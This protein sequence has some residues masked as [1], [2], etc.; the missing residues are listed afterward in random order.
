MF[1]G[2]YELFVAAS[3][4]DRLPSACAGCTESEKNRPCSRRF[5]ALAW[6]CGDR[7]R[8][9]RDLYPL[10]PIF[11][12]RRRRDLGQELNAKNAR[13]S[14]SQRIRRS[15][16][17]GEPHVLLARDQPLG[18]FTVANDDRQQRFFGADSRSPGVLDR[19]F[20]SLSIHRPISFRSDASSRSTALK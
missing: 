14:P 2:S 1:F 16:Q 15:S 6:H 11:Q 12:S 19:E 4:V 7:R 10:A 20:A 3:I 13:L 9:E 18:T 5:L 8:D 17:I